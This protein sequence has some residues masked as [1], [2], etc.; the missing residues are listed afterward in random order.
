MEGNEPFERPKREVRKITHNFI[1][2]K[3]LSLM[4]ILMICLTLAIVTAVAGI[5]ACLIIQG[6]I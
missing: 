3:K 5:L 2:K 4:A 6:N 1:T